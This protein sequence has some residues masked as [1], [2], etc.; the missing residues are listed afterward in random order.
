MRNVVNLF[1]FNPPFSCSVSLK[2][3]LEWLIGFHSS[4]G[5]LAP[6]TS[7]SYFPGVVHGVGVEACEPQRS[8][9]TWLSFRFFS[10]EQRQGI[11]ID[12]NS[13]LHEQVDSFAQ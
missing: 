11:S 12:K 10:T 5:F 3:A 8:P 2:K 1:F 4:V 6:T 13:T 9:V 7:S